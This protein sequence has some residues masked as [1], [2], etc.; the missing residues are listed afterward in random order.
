MCAPTHVVDQ[1]FVAACCRVVVGTPRAATARVLTHP[2]LTPRRLSS[3]LPYETCCDECD[4]GV[5][6]LCNRHH[7]QHAMKP[8]NAATAG[9][10]CLSVTHHQEVLKWH[11]DCFVPGVSD[12]EL[13]VL[14]SSLVDQARPRKSRIPA[15][16]SQFVST[17]QQDFTE[18]CSHCFWGAYA[19]CLVV[20]L[21]GLSSWIVICDLGI[22][23]CRTTRL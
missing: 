5:S 8:R 22:A 10:V 23:W 17:Y 7:L 15:E 20:P 11:V 12:A 13:R 16:G 4:S 18:A 2:H 19:T 3:V 6:C 21:A 1:C 14:I 9:C